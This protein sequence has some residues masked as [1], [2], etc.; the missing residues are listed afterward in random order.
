[1]FVMESQQQRL[2]QMMLKLIF[3]MRSWLGWMK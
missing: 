3:L 1:M 2:E